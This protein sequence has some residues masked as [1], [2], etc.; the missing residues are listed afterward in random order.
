L[1]PRYVHQFFEKLK[2]ANLETVG[3][4]AAIS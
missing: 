1:K 2:F 3:L 4:E